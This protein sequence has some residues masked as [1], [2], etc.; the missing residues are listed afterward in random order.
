MSERAAALAERFE[1]INQDLIVAVERC[2]DADWQRACAGEGWPV[3]VTAHHVATSY[4]AFKG[5]IQGIATGADL[6]PVTPEMLDAS[7]AQHAEEHAR[8]SRQ[9]TLE[10]LRRGGQAAAEAVRDL[11]DEQLDRTAPMAL[12]GGAAISAQQMAEF[13]IGHPTGHLASIQAALGG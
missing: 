2:S 3:G 10:L 8:C 5:F 11:S 12:A 9:E 4:P 1:R 6:P 13:M 7:N